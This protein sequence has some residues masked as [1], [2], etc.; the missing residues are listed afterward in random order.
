MELN[1]Y[2]CYFRPIDEDE[3]DPKLK[4]ISASEVRTLAVDDNGGMW[5]EPPRSLFACTDFE[6][7]T[8]EEGVQT[9]I[10]LCLATAESDITEVFYGRN[11]T[12]QM[13]DHLD[14]FTVDDY[15]DE[16]KVITSS[17]ASN[18]MTASLWYDIVNSLTRL[19]K[20]PIS[21]P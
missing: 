5:V 8:D 16:R 17:T 3:N 15:G 6:A 14:Q 4:N 12:A 1:S 10:M 7:V 18:P 19:P 13:L 9:P 2:Q 20:V 11:C 21:C